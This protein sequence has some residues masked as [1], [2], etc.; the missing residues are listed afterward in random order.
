[1]VLIRSNQCKMNVLLAENVS[2]TDQIICLTIQLN[3]VR[4]IR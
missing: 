1:M 2:E 3:K 4:L